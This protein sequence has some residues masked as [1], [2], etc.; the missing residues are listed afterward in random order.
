MRGLTV[1]GVLVA[2]VAAAWGMFVPVTGSLLGTSYSCGVPVLRAFV[3]SDDPNPTVRAAE[4]GCRSDSIVRLFLGGLGFVIGAV[5]A[6]VGLAVGKPV[7]PPAPPPAVVAVP[8]LPP[9]FDGH[10]WWWH[11]GYG[12]HPFDAEPT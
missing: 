2:V 7:P 1:G 6:I 10:R 11:D 5:M 3:E 8:V 12:W 9:R 4:Q